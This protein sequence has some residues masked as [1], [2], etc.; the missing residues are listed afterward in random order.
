MYSNMY[1]CI[2]T[3]GDYNTLEVLFKGL[4]IFPHIVKSK[5]NSKD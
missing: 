2:V 1:V 5:I 3:F 4:K